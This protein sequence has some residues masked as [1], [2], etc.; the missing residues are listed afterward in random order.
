M[1]EMF[2]GSTIFLHDLPPI[3]PSGLRRGPGRGWNR[4]LQAANHLCLRQEAAHDPALSKQRPDLEGPV[5]L[6]HVL[7]SD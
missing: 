4:Q 2:Q 1:I 7:L 3:I 5:G 6:K